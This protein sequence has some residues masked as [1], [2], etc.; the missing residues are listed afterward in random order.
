MAQDGFDILLMNEVE[1]RQW[2]EDHPA[3]VNSERLL[4]FMLSNANITWLV[5]EKGADVNVQGLWGQTP[6]LSSWPR[7][8]IPRVTE[9]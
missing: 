8:T 2:L 6:R 9:P 3:L 4:C 5:D 7:S 1:L